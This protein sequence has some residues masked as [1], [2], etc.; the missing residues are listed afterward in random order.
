[1]LE[2]SSKRK[3]SIYDGADAGN[4]E[5]LYLHCAATN[6]QSWE[7]TC[8]RLRRNYYNPF[9]QQLQLRVVVVDDSTN[10][11][12][13]AECEVGTCL[14][15]L[16]LYC[17]DGEPLY[18]RLLHIVSG[19]DPVD[20]GFMQPELVD[21]FLPA[22]MV[23]HCIWER[24]LKFHKQ[25]TTK[26]RDSS[27]QEVESQ[28]P[29]KSCKAAG[30]GHSTPRGPGPRVEE[31]EKAWVG[32][33]DN[34]NDQ[35]HDGNNADGD[36]DGDVNGDDVDK[37]LAE[38]FDGDGDMTDFNVEEEDED[39]D[40]HA[41]GENL[42]DLLLELIAAQKEEDEEEKEN[43]LNLDGEESNTKCDLDLGIEEFPEPVH[44]SE[45]GDDLPRPE[46]E[47]QVPEVPAVAKSEP[48]QSEGGQ[49]QEPPPAPKSESTRT[50]KKAQAKSEPSCYLGV[51]A[52]GAQS[53]SVYDPSTVFI[54]PASLVKRFHPAAW[55]CFR[56]AILTIYYMYGMMVGC[57]V[58]ETSQMRGQG[59]YKHLT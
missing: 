12:G 46:A 15:F 8:L 24:P 32:D 43:D 41:N 51:A 4:K 21:V 50:R 48:P 29:R 33:S 42:S 35:G 54:G 52:S 14:E 57:T 45:L 20:A 40:E 26:K 6:F 5:S 11:T 16:K 10:D 44:P 47:A 36:G 30:G 7:T 59:S 19:N 9:T 55:A 2:L 23:W 3:Q 39:Q 34:D 58:S 1:M 17:D 56:K 38:L 31:K 28:R 53:S 49:E 25:K 22:G 27:N 18:V 37:I 13:A